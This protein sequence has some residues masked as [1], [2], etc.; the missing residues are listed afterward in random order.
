MSRLDWTEIAASGLWPAER[1]PASI[2][3]APRPEPQA[4]QIALC[5]EWLSRF[6][7]KTIA[8]RSRH[9]SY[10]YKHKVE[11]WAGEYISNGAFIVAAIAEGH[12]AKRVRPHSP[13]A[14]FNIAMR[15]MSK[16]SGA[17]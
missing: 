10:F 7:E 13:N 3:G 11:Q 5:R 8:I 1:L 17:A 15:A 2:A 4:E 9:S 12:R 6:A 16:P 14:F